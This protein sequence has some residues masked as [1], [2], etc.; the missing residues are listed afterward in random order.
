MKPQLHQTHQPSSTHA[1]TKTN[2]DSHRWR[3][4]LPPFPRAVPPPA[5]PTEDRKAEILADPR[6]EGGGAAGI[7]RRVCWMRVRCSC[8]VELFVSVFV[9]CCVCCCLPSMQPPPTQPT[10]QTYKQRRVQE[11]RDRQQRMKAGQAPVEEP[12]EAA[13]EK[14][15]EL[16]STKA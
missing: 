15:K 7:D 14:S 3:V 4:G 1:S 2:P 8:T 6:C 10:K 9:F 12:Q 13:A 5:P 16:V 11:V